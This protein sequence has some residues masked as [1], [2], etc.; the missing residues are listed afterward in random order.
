M[1]P[2]SLIFIIT[3]STTKQASSPSPPSLDFVRERQL[4]DTTRE[5]RSIDDTAITLTP[6]LENGP[7]KKFSTA[8]LPS[9]HDFLPLLPFQLR[10]SPEFS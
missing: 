5:V 7:R 3:S 8:D 4:I 9:I 6:G 2:P 10:A 1:I